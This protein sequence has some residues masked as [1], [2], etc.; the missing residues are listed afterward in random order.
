MSERVDRLLSV[1]GRTYAEEAGIRLADTPAPLYQLLVLSVVLSTR[2]RAS[3][4]MAAARELFDAGFT[5]PPRMEEADRHAVI[6]A[7]HRGHYVRYDGMMASALHDGATLVQERWRGDLRRMRREAD[8]DTGRLEELVQQVPRLGPTGAAIFCREAQAVWPELRPYV[9]RKAL[10][11]AA[12][13][14]LPADREALA[15]EVP[16]DAT[17]TLAAALVRAALD[18]RVA[19]QVN[20][21]A[22]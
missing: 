6:D 19:A 10:D 7:L 22:A 17:A 3:V 1:A 20:A 15:A 16:A 11:G 13:V 14:G 4:G 9:D 2:V 5:T 12:R 21:A 18:R 8:G